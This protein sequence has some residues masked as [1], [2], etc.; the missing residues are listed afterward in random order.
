MLCYQELFHYRNSC[1]ISQ[2]E[3]FYLNF[4]DFVEYGFRFRSKRVA[5][6]NNNNIVLTSIKKP[7]TEIK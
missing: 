4:Q 3:T 5:F 2:L 6:R 1:E 7:T